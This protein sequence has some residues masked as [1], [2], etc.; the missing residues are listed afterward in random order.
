MAM[1][2]Q[3]SERE[4]MP[5]TLPSA[6]GSEPSGALTVLRVTHAAVQAA[7]DEP[8][9]VRAVCQAIVDVAAFRFAAIARADAECGTLQRVASSAPLPDDVGESGSPQLDDSPWGLAAREAL[10]AGRPFLVAAGQASIL[11]LLPLRDATQVLGVLQIASARVGDFTAGSVDLL[12][13]AANALAYGMVVLR[14]AER[15]AAVEEA[16]RRV[17]RARKTLSEANRALVRA[18]E[19]QGLLQDICRIIVE[20]G[21]YR[22]AWVGYAQ[23]DEAKSVAI[24]AFHG[25]D[26]AFLEWQRLTWGEGERGHGATGV[27]I[28]TGQPSIGRSIRSDAALAPWRDEDLRRGI[29]AVSAF[30]LRHGDEILGNLTIAA[31]EEDAF[32]EA[33]ASLLGELAEDLSFGIATLRLR[34]RSRQAQE[35]IKRMAEEDALTGLPNRWRLRMRLGTEIDAAKSHSG[36][37]ALLVLG[38]NHFQ[39]VNE[40]LGY[41]QGDAMLCEVATRIRR[42][43]QDASAIARVGESEFAILLPRSD[44][45]AASRT[46]QRLLTELLEPV[47]IGEIMLDAGGSIGIAVF[48][49]HGTEAD[50]L[51]RRANVAMHQARQQGHGHALY[52]GGRDRECA[53]RLALIG[54]LHRA[55]DN[56]EMRLYCQ[57]KA[58]L[59]SGELC[60]VEAL[61]RWEHPQRGTLWPNEFISLAE[62]SGLISP[63]TDWVM[64]AA[65]RQSYVWRQDGL[66]VP[67]AVNLSAR[68]L[69]DPKLIERVR[70]HFATWGAEP[71]D[72]Q[73]ELTESALMQDPQGS[74][75]CL[76]RLKDLGTALFIDDFGTGYSS[77]AYLQRLPVDAI[78]IDKSFVQD[79][80]SNTDS[81]VIVRSTIDLAHDLELEVVAEGVEDRA[82]WEHLSAQGCD[83]AQGYVISEPLRAEAFAAWRSERA[84]RVQQRH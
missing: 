51:I 36:P 64:Q 63:L 74:L 73:F 72:I 20:D 71:E 75:E 84:Q 83:V 31:T 55:I 30:P 66:S 47:T 35:T 39:E 1:D 24:M 79:M 60:G 4:E 65:F 44:A 62:H 80:L 81:N 5:P 57:P 28:R 22:F 41:Q 13:E 25:I 77:L 29:A 82:G 50:A 61:V 48:P 17:D 8:G 7:M 43:V 19:E 53:R 56:G 11:A 49:G 78:K 34:E 18:T 37:L 14:R 32:D 10:Q 33:E 16:L 42:V 76:Q 27:A 46:A 26:R 58:R 69:R 54:D 68:D 52:T 67:V 38:V 59:A 3:L 6:A 2:E 23:H 9:L 45:A 21:G 15:H 40:T 12:Q 70:N